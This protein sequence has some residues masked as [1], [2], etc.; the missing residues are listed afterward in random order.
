VLIIFSMAG[1]GFGWGKPVI[2]NPQNF[3]DPRKGDIIVSAAGPA[4]NLLLAIVLGIVVRTG[5][6]GLPPSSPYYELITVALEVNIVLFLFNLIPVPPLDG[7]HILADLLPYPMAKSYQA[8]MANYGWILIVLLLV[9]GSPLLSP[10]IYGIE[11]V[12]A[13]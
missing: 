6:L 10:A 2:T 4:M 13:G 7:A 5:S 8:A 12:L 1:L 3:K 11:K 9:L